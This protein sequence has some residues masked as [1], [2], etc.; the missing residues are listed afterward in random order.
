MWLSL[1][2]FHIAT[3]GETE[4]AKQRR[5]HKSYKT[6]DKGVK[7]F[8]TEKGLK[9]KLTLATN[10]K[11]D[12]IPP[13]KWKDNMCGVFYYNQ[14]V[15]LRKCKPVTLQRGMCY[16]R[17]RSIFIPH[18]FHSSKGCR[19]QFE[20]KMVTLNCIKSK[21]RYEKIKTY[22]KITACSCQNVR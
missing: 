18:D 8:K 19:P 7:S 22:K 11:T 9:H 10:S 3:V 15:K 20:T 5:R 14:T 13:A 1:L 4:L 2:V 12:I 17:C 16:G 21:V 6:T